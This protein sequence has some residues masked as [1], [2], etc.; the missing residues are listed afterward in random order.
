[1]ISPSWVLRMCGHAQPMPMPV[2][3]CVSRESTEPA[4]SVPGVKSGIASIRLAR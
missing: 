2:L 4:T 1:M 3:N